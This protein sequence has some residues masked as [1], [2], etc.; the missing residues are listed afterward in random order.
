[1]RSGTFCG[2]KGLGGGVGGMRCGASHTTSLPP[3]ASQS[4]LR[5]L[6]PYPQHTEQ[7]PQPSKPRPP[8]VPLPP[9]SRSRS[10]ACAGAH[11]LAT[12][13]SQHTPIQGG[14][15]SR[16]SVSVLGADRVDLKENGVG[17]VNEGEH[18]VK[19]RAAYLGPTV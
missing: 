16:L 10:C 3:R 1:M 5:P 17:G 11:L 8:T 14:R 6:S 7:A 2:L 12:S 19:R 4:I 15:L 13:V 18:A 9:P